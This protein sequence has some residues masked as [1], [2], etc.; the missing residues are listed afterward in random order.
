M[1][2]RWIAAALVAAALLET[3][4]A[5]PAQAVETAGASAPGVE[6]D[7]LEPLNRGGFWFNDRLDVFVIEPAAKGWVFITPEAFRTAL[8]R[9]MDNVRFPIR[10]VANL[11]QGRVRGAGVETGRFVVNTTVGLVGFFDP[12]TGWG[13]EAQDADIGQAFG[14]WGIPAG[15]YL[16]LPLFGPSNPRDGVGLAGESGIMFL[17]TRPYGIYISG[18]R[19]LNLRAQNIDTIRDARQASLDYYVAVRN[20]YIQYRR[21]R[22]QGIDAA[23]ERRDEEDLYELEEFEDEE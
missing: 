11:L 12:A 3:P 14:R 5:V 13:I 18:T 4:G 2:T 17:L 6:S 20:A 16:V 10:F 21:A 9:A 19:L 8:G 7:P 15:P 1:R 23:E 22:V